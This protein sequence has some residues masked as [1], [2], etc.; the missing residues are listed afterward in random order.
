MV[1]AHDDPSLPAVIPKSNV[2]FAFSLPLPADQDGKLKDLRF[3][4]LGSN[5]VFR[6]ADRA[7]K[8]FKAKGAKGLEY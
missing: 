6:G 8:K 2:T 3:E 5:F 7:S 4:L 1:M